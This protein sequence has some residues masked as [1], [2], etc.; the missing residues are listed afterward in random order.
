MAVWIK[1]S[2]LSLIDTGRVGGRALSPHITISGS[3]GIERT[4]RSLDT[5][6]VEGVRG[7]DKSTKKLSV[8]LVE[9][10][11]EGDEEAFA[12][13]YEEYQLRIYEYLAGLVGKSDAYDLLQDTFIKMLT[14]IGTLQDATKFTSW[15]FRIARNCAYDHLRRKYRYQVLHVL[16]EFE[17]LEVSDDHMDMIEYVIQ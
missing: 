5:S 15:L 12:A 7:D 13:L 14:R 2:S 4:P 9:R 6:L 3:Q 16:E 17:T 10:L 1:D 11:R 8:Q